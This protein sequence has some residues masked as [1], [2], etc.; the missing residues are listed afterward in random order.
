M[1]EACKRNS[2]TLTRTSATRTIIPLGGKDRLSLGKE[3]YTKAIYEFVN[4]EACIVLTMAL[5]VELAF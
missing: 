2:N 4:L 1:H 3:I 5:D